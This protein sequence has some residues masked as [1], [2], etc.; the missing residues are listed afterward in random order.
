MI[1]WRPSQELVVLVCY[2][3][4]LYMTVVDNTI[5]YTA[6][7]SLARDFHA[8]AGRRAVGDAE[9]PAHAGPD[10]PVVGLDR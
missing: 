6:L 4:A 8:S 9:L 2:T 5:I 7:P 3:T 1:R 10:D